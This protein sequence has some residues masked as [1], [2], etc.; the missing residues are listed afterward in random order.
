MG[1]MALEDRPVAEVTLIV[2]LAQTTL[3]AGI[4]IVLPLL[5]FKRE[6]L[7]APDRGASWFTSQGWAWASSS[8]R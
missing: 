4:L 1:R 7:R 3:I 2:L 6:D 8:L 5:R